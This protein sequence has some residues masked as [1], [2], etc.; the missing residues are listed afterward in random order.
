[1]TPLVDSGL[2]LGLAAAMLLA[3][4]ASVSGQAGQGEGQGPPAAGS[5]P[6]ALTVCAV[7]SAMP[8]TGR[9]PD[10]TP[11]GLDVAVVQSLGKN[12][13][14]AI[15]FHWC[16]SA[17]CGWSCLPEGRCDVVIGQPLDSGPPR[18]VAWSVPYA[19]AQ[20]GLVVAGAAEGVASLADLRG[21]RVGVVTGTV[22][23]SEGDHT[24][25]RFKTREELLDGFQ[26]ARL[27]AAF[28]DAD[29]A[30]WYL[31]QRPRLGLRLV[32]GYVPRERWN[33]A[34]AVRARD[35]ALLAEINQAL[36]RLAGSGELRNVYSGYGVPFRPPFTA[37]ARQPSAPNTW[38]RVLDRKELV[39]SM[40][41]A[42][43]PYSSARDDNPG[44]D[45]ELAR[46]L[47][48][49]LNLKL[50]ID[51]LDVHRESAVGELLERRCDL[52]LGAAVDVKAVADDEELAGKV[53]Y[54]RPYYGTG[55]VLVGRK[56]GPRAGSLA[57]LKGA[58]AQRLG[59]EAGS[60][61]DY[62]LRQR[63]YLRQLFR[64]Q[65]AALKALND[66][67]I[68]FAY[69][70]ANVGWTLHASPDFDL[71]LVAGYV[72]EDHWNIAIA[73]CRGDD[74][75]KRQ[76]DAALEP[77]IRDGTVARTLARYHVPYFDPFP[78][79]AP[80]PGRDPQGG[81][82]GV[83]RHAVADR[84]REPEMGRVQASKQAYSALARVR[85]AGE[86][87]VGLDQNNLPLSTAHPHP[88]GLDH[89]IAGLLADRL[90]VSL[91]VYWAYS[92]HDSYPSKLS[93]KKLC[94]VILG[95]MPDARFAERVLYSRPYYSATYRLVVR[96]GEG[97]LSPTDPVAVEE[98]VAVRGLEGR[99]VRPYPSTE[100]ILEAVATGRVKA[101]YVISTRG[102]WLAH[103][104]W[105]GKLTFLPAPRSV[106]TFPISAAVRKTDRDL[107]EAIDQ[108]WDELGQSNRL[109]EVFAHWQIPY[110]PVA[111]HRTSSEP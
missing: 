46:A 93:S 74:E 62:R 82:G 96:S 31:H 95:V 78:E 7:P 48:K 5:R 16:A 70:W 89:E 80:L 84:G 83:I 6:K 33:M 41:P 12:L 2:R 37:T 43:L 1:M 105:P 111:A 13:G 11:E 65:L 29:F 18:E 68:D 14:R 47:A 91:R 66:G 86:L 88:A 98:G 77:L 79:P 51:W 107:K 44:F 54:S 3:S 19:G 28:V 97:P 99:E 69:L 92:A 90:G 49:R 71:R 30:A 56:D 87:V 21:K 67:Q 26:A 32:D 58:R 110:E 50:R 108:A 59:A 85:S 106:D 81:A 27:D 45:V 72:P 102:P 61:A 22:S 101:G 53:L 42:N 109:A 52:V 104:R 35:S 10:G 34:L 38:R 57:E 75:L 17:E 40:D 24:V 8:R 76:V 23:L 103:Q 73:M 39:V 64:N 60:I 100:A 63:G 94:D 9:T 25:V 55:Y 36:A 15:E 20:F 4:G